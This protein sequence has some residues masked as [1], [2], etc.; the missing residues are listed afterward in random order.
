[1][2]SIRRPGEGGPEVAHGEAPG[3]NRP[4]GWVAYV[5]FRRPVEPV[6]PKRHGN[7]RHGNFSQEM[8]ARRQR[9]RELRRWISGGYVGPS[10]LPQ[11][12]GWAGFRGIYRV[13]AREAP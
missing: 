7:F 4:S 1:M 12:M 6:D 10:P 8:A 13:R 9:L 11:P 3:R 2:P 5:A